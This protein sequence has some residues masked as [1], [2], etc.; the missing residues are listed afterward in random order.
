MVHNYV[1]VR[2]AMLTKHYNDVH[3]HAVRLDTLEQASTCTCT[4]MYMNV[5]GC[6][7]VCVHSMYM[8]VHGYVH[9]VQNNTDIMTPLL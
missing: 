9:C 4:S 2:L 7:H 3:G 1:I 5:H 8:N 6:V